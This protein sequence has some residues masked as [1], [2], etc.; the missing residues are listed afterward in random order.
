[1]GCQE[2]SSEPQRKAPGLW[3]RGFEANGSDTQQ[4]HSQ[5]GARTIHVVIRFKA[6]KLGQTRILEQKATYY[7]SIYHL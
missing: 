1:M 4:L 3:K 2:A 5:G 6:L 7:I